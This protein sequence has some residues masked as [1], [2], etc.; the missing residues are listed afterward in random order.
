MTKLVAAAFSLLF[1]PLVS[2]AEAQETR[3]MEFLLGA[4]QNELSIAIEYED[5]SVVDAALEGSR[6]LPVRLVVKNISGRAVR[7]DYGDVRLNLNGDRRLEPVDVKV[8]EQEIRRTKRFPKL[9]NFLASQSTSFHRTGIQQLRLG[10]G[11]I[12]AGASKA[13][14]VFF[15]RPVDVRRDAFNGVMALETT[16]YAPQMLETKDI[17]VK[18]KPVTEPTFVEKM[19]QLAREQLLGQKP[20]FNKS[21]ALLI[22][23]GKYVHL[24][25]LASPAQ[26]VR[27]MAEYLTAQGFDEVIAVRDETVTMKMLQSPQ[28][29]F[30]NKIQPDDRFLFYYSGH[31]VSRLE[32]GSTRGYLPLVDE[33]P[34][35]V[36]RS[37]PMDSLVSWMNSM[38]PT[39]LLVILDS[40]FSGLAVQGTEFKS[41][42]PF[43]KVDRPTLDVLSRGSARYLL[44]AGAEDE[45]SVADRRWGGSLFTDALLRGLRSAKDVDMYGDHIITTRELYPWLKQTV[46]LEARKLN[47]SLTPL[48]K[49]LDPNGA[50]KGD[51]VFV[52]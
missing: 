40:C 4:R 25:P 1:F 36:S 8:V 39:H 30:K 16:R 47:Q 20:S 7:F 32:G 19:T 5:P 49:D 22:G 3:K 43:A 11:N 13:G 14:F 38:N 42:N 21:Y 27:K 2:T 23:I 48:L 44:M 9:L 17:V 15:L 51:F 33:R 46:A 12:A 31:G 28:R 10:D 52:R 18:T 26:D 6:V 34:G 50:S 35:S 45:K 41:E 29:Y 37:I 24:S